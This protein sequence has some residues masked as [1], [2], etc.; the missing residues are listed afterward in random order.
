[1][2]RGLSELQVTILALAYRNYQ[3]RMER[4]ATLEAGSIEYRVLTEGVPSVDLYHPEV[5]REHFGFEVQ[6]DWWTPELGER[7]TGGQNFSMQRIGERRYRS[8]QSSLSRAVVR[9]EAR[10]LVERRSGHPAGL[11]LTERGVEEAERREL[12][13]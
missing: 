4:M 8:A 11:N 3:A 10:G 6:S 2:G 9:L 5:L 13:S 1:M 12:R 7:P